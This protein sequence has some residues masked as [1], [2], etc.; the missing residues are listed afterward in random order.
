MTNQRYE[1]GPLVKAWLKEPTFVPAANLARVSAAIAHTPQRPGRRFRF[2]TMRFQTMFDATKAAAAVAI[3][4][5]SGVLLT[6]QLLGS[7]PEPGEVPALVGAPAS[8]VAAPTER[9]VESDANQPLSIETSDAVAS[10]VIDTPA[11]PAPWVRLDGN[12]LGL[13]RRG[14]VL[15]WGDGIAVWQDRYWDESDQ[16]ATPPTLY[17]SRDGVEWRVVELPPEVQG[18]H[19]VQLD[20][21]GG[22]TVLHKL[23]DD[24]VWTYAN[25]GWQPVDTT[26]LQE[27]RVQGWSASDPSTD[28][29]QLVDGELAVGTV[30]PYV[31]PRAKLGVKDGMNAVLKRL[32][33]TRYALCRRS[34]ECPGP[35]TAIVRFKQTDDGLVVR[36]DRTGERL[37]VLKGAR[38]S[39]LY[40][41][42]TGG[43]GAA[44]TL[45][46]NVLVPRF[47]ALPKPTRNRTAGAP[48][49]PPA[50]TEPYA[51]R[52]NALL[53]AVLEDMDDVFGESDKG[54]FR[55][56]T[57]WWLHIG[58]DWVDLADLQIPPALF[59]QSSVEAG[60]AGDLVLIWYQTQGQND[61]WVVQKPQTS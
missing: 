41:G 22:T 28:G 40:E 11:G 37:G 54:R 44:Y 35:N 18:S 42:R 16:G 33:G 24:L 5:L 56:A 15:P 31:L 12:G 23:S 61:L 17:A 14:E 59:Y 2:P 21:I 51:S 3:L 60:T 46:D 19:V 8:S 7:A 43:L 58:G 38:A 45:V 25:D 53:A 52:G 27:A 10:G 30:Q 13:P 20:H 29:F 32:D 6:T 39:Q 36:D 1:H 57:E 4:G 34:G 47:D 50:G 26:A 48:D 9:A 49:L 55:S